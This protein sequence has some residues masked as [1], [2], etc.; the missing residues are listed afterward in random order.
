MSEEEQAMRAQEAQARIDASIPQG[1]LIVPHIRFDYEGY[2]SL[3]VNLL[4]LPLEDAQAFVE[5]QLQHLV[6]MVNSLKPGDT[7]ISALPPSEA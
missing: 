3:A 2:Y 1:I 6:E 4:H 7:V 5:R